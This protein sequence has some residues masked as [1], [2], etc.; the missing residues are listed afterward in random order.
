M[1]L[2]VMSGIMLVEPFVS[3]FNE[4]PLA[5]QFA[6]T[7]IGYAISVPVRALVYK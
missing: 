7:Y 2:L 6:V 5:C 3:V 4:S 1:C